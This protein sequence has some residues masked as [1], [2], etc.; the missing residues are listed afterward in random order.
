ML[1]PQGG[2]HYIISPLL[3][4]S[5]SAITTLLVRFG[6]RVDSKVFCYET[7]GGIE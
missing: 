7:P 4:V 3:S 5:P 2:V 6:A 1:G